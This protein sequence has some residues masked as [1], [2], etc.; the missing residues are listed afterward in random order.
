MKAALS[1]PISFCSVIVHRTPSNQIA[2][3]ARSDCVRHPIR[4]RSVND[5]FCFVC[6]SIVRYAFIT[7]DVLQEVVV[8]LLVVYFATVMLQTVAHHEII[9]V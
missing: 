8:A 5:D 2:D 4:L 1:Y 9:Y 7:R 3:A 6:K